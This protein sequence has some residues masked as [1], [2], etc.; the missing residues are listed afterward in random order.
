MVREGLGSSNGET[1]AIDRMSV[2]VPKEFNAGDI[3]RRE[4]GV[5]GGEAYIELKRA[6]LWW[7][8][9]GR[10]GCVAVAKGPRSF[11]DTV[12]YADSSSRNLLRGLFIGGWL[13]SSLVFCV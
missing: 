8:L 10:V 13:P 1:S 5:G 7:P 3:G 12:P 4:K 6:S 9:C 11:K 2:I